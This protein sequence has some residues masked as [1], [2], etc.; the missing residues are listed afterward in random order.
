MDNLTGCDYFFPQRSAR[1]WATGNLFIFKNC[2]SGNDGL[3]AI[4]FDTK[5]RKN[6]L[7]I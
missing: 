2:K 5:I 6:L 1:I 7:K 3:V 4:G